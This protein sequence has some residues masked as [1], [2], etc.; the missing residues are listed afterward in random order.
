MPL[1]LDG[2]DFD[3]M[4]P[5]VIQKILAMPAME[6][7]PGADTQI[8]PPDFKW[9]LLCVVLCMAISGIFIALRAYTKLVVVK[10]VDAADCK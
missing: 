5:A 9:Y 6:P 7:P 4:P 10:Q 8:Q 3:T 2:V 1:S